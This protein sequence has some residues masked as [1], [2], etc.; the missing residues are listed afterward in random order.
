M[1]GQLKIILIA[2]AFSGIVAGVILTFAQQLALT[3][4]ILAAEELELTSNHEDWHPAD[5]LERTL[6]TAAAN[7]VTT[8]SFALLLGAAMSLRS[9][10][11]AWSS[12]LLWGIGGYLAFFVAPSLGLPPELPGSMAAE[13]G[14]R[15]IWWLATVFFTAT[16][17]AFLSFSPM[18]FTKIVGL[19]L[20]VSPHFITA[21]L[22]D[23]HSSSV[24][25][26]MTEA[27]VLAS[28]LV[29]AVMW[30]IIGSLYGLI[31]SR[32][33]LQSEQPGSPL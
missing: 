21:P 18:P 28:S 6:F 10:N 13:L 20:V 1:P 23:T 32:L 25:S 33:L 3:P 11:P 30:I 14:S 22:P 5:G 17:L 2:A 12:G 8:F 7:I 27:F 4:L 16:G 15:Q 19:L 31:Y 24:P 26:D 9:D 29:N